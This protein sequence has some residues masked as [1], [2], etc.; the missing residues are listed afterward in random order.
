MS[1][2]LCL[3][4]AVLARWGLPRIGQD[5]IGEED[6]RFRAYLEARGWDTRVMGIGGGG[7][8][9]GASTEGGNKD[10]SAETGAPPIGGNFKSQT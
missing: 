10:Q 7:K 4:S 5:T 8:G 3:L 6:R 9:V 1:A 2:S